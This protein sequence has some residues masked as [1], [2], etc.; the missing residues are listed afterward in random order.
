MCILA[1]DCVSERN[2]TYSILLLRCTKVA[3]YDASSF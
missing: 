1:D 2:K 3:P